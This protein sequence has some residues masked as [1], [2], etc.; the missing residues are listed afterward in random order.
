MTTIDSGA[1]TSQLI[2]RVGEQVTLL[3]LSDEQVQSASWRGT[4]T[5]NL[6]FTGLTSA[7]AGVYTCGGTTMNNR[8]VSHSVNITVSREFSY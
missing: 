2:G 5:T 1:H 6:T 8:E 4:A 7:N 3:C